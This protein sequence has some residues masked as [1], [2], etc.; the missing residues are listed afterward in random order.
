MFGGGIDTAE[1]ELMAQALG[2]DIRDDG[3]ADSDEVPIDGMAYLRSVMREAKKEKQVVVAPN[4]NAL[5]AVRPRD[6][7][8]TGRQVWIL[9]RHRYVQS[10][11]FLQ[12]Q[13]QLVFSPPIRLTGRRGPRMLAESIYQRRPG[14]GRGRTSLQ[15]SG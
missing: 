12:E 2:A 4:A 3:T 8:Y 11:S 10:H 14:Y 6:A 5:T 1:D 15:E 7:V 9:S 13:C